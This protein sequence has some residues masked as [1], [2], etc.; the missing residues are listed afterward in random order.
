M[1]KSIKKLSLV[2]ALA[3]SLLLIFTSCTNSKA[4]EAN[5]SD[6]KNLSKVELKMYILGDKPGDFDK[7]Y[8]EINKLMTEKINATLNV[9]FI[10]WDDKD[11]KYP[12]LFS[13]KDDFDL[14]FTATGWCFY[15]QIATSNG[16]YEMSDD[17][18]QKYAPKTW[19]NEPKEAWDQAKVNGKVY[20]VPND[21]NE[22]AYSVF[23]IRGDLREKYGIPEI[24][25]VEDLEKYYDAIAKNEKGIIPIVNGLDLQSP[26][27]MDGK[28]LAYVRGTPVP[29]IGYNIND[30]SA[31]LFAFV[32]IPEYKDYVTNMKKDAD[33]NYWL[34]DSK[35]SGSRDDAFKKGTAASMVW[36]LNTVAKDVQEVNRNHP[37]WKAE[38][39]DVFHG[40]N[41][42]INQYTNN[43]LAINAKSKNPERA[44]MALDLLRYD[45]DIYDLTNYGIKGT[46]WEPVGDSMYT[47][48]DGT[49]NFPAGNVCPWGW[50]TNLNRMDIYQ[51]KVVKAFSDK[52]T[53]EDMVHNP[54]ETFS[55]DDSKVKNEVEAVNKVI[56]QYGVPLDLGKVDPTTGIDTY[57]KEL[58]KAGLYKM[59]DEV[60][61]QANDYMKNSK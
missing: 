59:L 56:T 15:N 41:K 11:T 53:S 8:A 31:K 42:F 54:L 32:D 51:P 50:H 1:K 3:M 46:H 10:S 58:E 28:E 57:K 24:K 37:E 40:A 33:N 6:T 47:V 16:F 38:V 45:Q 2:L 52:W 27:L 5:T 25:S 60:Q 13:S 36:N 4:K 39:V 23:G 26:Y 22:Y 48:L 19:N 43:G 61:K 7:V 34:K 30:K 12:S 9:E 55:F 29:A 49:S 21:Q 44:M 18:I 35:S 17:F 14:T 20:M